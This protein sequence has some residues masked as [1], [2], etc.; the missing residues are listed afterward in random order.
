MTFSITLGWWLVPVIVTVGAFVAYA[1]WESVQK[2]SGGD[3]GRI[4]DAV[5]GLIVF[6]GALILALVAWLIYLGLVVAL[7]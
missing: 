6:G 3:Y 1:W 4:G 7:S 2:P 5:G